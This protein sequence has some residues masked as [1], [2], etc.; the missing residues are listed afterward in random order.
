MAH[1]LKSIKAQFKEHGVFYT[2]EK[3]A[4]LL[5]SYMPADLDRVYDPTCGDGALLSQFPDNVVKYGQELDAEQAEAARQRLTNAVIAVGD[6]LKAPDF[7]GF[8]YRG[9]VANPPFSVKWEPKGDVRFDDAPCLSPQSKA[10]YAFLLHILYY[11]ADDGVAAVLNFPGI[12]YRGNREGKIRQWMVEQNVID[13][14]VAIEGGYFVDTKI[15]TALLILKKNRTT[16]DIKFIDHA[17]NISRMVP[18]D[19]VRANG[20]SLSVSQYVQPSQ[21]EKPKVDPK[22]LEH[23]AQEDAI[24]RITAELKFSQ[25][26]CQ[27]EGMNFNDFCDRIIAVVES[28]KKKDDFFEK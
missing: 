8:K 27:F 23:R 3:L 26:V 25:M 22:A 14:V 19:E 16:T 28:F 20:F 15:A 1:N 7:I 17:L 11:L 5:K 6:T 13:E 4:A 24:K 10:D 18:F 12:L 21:P 2:D 9:I